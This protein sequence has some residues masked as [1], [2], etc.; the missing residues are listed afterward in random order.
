MST[1]STVKTADSAPVGS[2]SDQI[3]KENL[4]PQFNSEDSIESSS[5]PATKAEAIQQ[6]VENGASKEEIKQIIKEFDLKVHGKSKKVKFDPTNDQE[7]VRMLQKAYAGDQAMQEKAEFEKA[8]QQAIL[9]A[10]QSPEGME[11]FLREVLGIDPDD[12]AE[13]KI[14]S[15]IEQLKKSPEQ[16]EKERIQKELELA[17]KMLKEKEEAAEQEKTTRLQE[18]AAVQLD[19]E[20]TDALSKDPELPKTRKTV[21]RIADAMLWAMDNGYPDVV[22][23]DVLPSIK[24]EIQAEFNEFIAELP[25]ELIEAYI[26]KKSLDKLRKKRIAANKA[27]PISNEVKPTAHVEKKVEEKAKI[28]SKDFFRK[29]QG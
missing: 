24:K 23:A 28:N 11:N 3:N 10:K 17:R 2:G 1:E 29:L 27:A 26:G 5:T 8:V 13:K 4:D 9:E 21:K 18:K 20:I 15:K 12:F 14:Q 7:I 16:L 6:A 25:E 22:V 19:Q